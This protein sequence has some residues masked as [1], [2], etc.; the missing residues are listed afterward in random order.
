MDATGKF[1]VYESGNHMFLWERSSRTG[2]LVSVRG[3]EKGNNSDYQGAIAPSRAQTVV[4]WASD[5]TNLV[6]GGKDTNKRDDIFMREVAR[7]ASSVTPATVTELPAR[8]VVRVKGSR[9]GVT[10]A[11]CSFCLF[12]P[13]IPGALVEASVAGLPGVTIGG[14]AATGVSVVSD[15]EIAFSTPALKAGSSY[16]VVISYADGEQVL[17]PVSLAAVSTPAPNADVD[18]DGLPDLWELT[19]GLDPN[20]AADAAAVGANG[21]TP[22]QARAQ[23]HHPTG[24]ANRYLAEGATNTLFHTRIAL[25]NPGDLPATALLRYAKKDGSLQTQT[26]AVPAMRRATVDVEALSGM[27]AAE[28]STAVESD[29]ALI[30]DRTLSWGGADAYG[31]H[32]ETAV[33]APALTWYLAEGATHSGFSLFYLLQNP[34]AAEARC[35]K[36]PWFPHG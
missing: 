4:V 9:M 31:A 5:S 21:L 20:M 8:T 17:L 15:G 30:V 11:I 28:F 3:A 18:V 16:P 24:T 27:G 19:Y 36:Y 12:I 22:V 10:E 23:Q 14:Q 34:N 25:A 2:Q 35:R 29:L 26:V 33:A 7:I 32:A 13:G 6:P 1:V